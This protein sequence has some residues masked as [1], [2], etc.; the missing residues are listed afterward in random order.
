MGFLEFVLLEVIRLRLEGLEAYDPFP[1]SEVSSL[2]TFKRILTC[3]TD[4]CADLSVLTRDCL[5]LFRGLLVLSLLTV[6]LHISQKVNLSIASGTRSKA[7][8]L[9]PELPLADF[10][11]VDKN[12]KDLSEADHYRFKAGCWRNM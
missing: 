10:R 4:A 6:E 9:N 3:T 12:P 11:G 7:L 5:L 8:N 1:R 2:P